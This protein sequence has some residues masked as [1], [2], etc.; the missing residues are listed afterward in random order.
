MLHLHTRLAVVAG[1][2]IACSPPAQCISWG[3][4]PRPR[5][6]CLGDP[7]PPGAVA[8]LGT[9]RFKHNSAAGSVTALHFLADGQTLVSGG[10]DAVS[11]WDLTTAK[12]L[13][14]FAASKGLFGP[15]VSLSGDSKVM[16]ITEQAEHRIQLRD[17][18]TGNV[19]RH[20]STGESDAFPVLAVDGRTVADVRAEGPIRA[21]GSPDGVIRLWDV[22]TGR[23]RRCLKGHDGYIHQVAFSPDG[24]ILAS[25]G[26]DSLVHLWNTTTG[27][28]THRLKG[29]P[30]AVFSVAFA[31]DAQTVA[32]GCDSC[33]RLWDA[34]TGKELWNLSVF[35]VEAL[36]FSPD[37]KTLASGCHTQVCLWDA[38]TGKKL[39]E[40]KGH[41][42]KVTA[43]A[44]SRD[45]KKLASGSLDRTIRLWDLATGKERLPLPGHKTLVTTLAYAP[46]GKVLATGDRVGQVILW[47]AATGKV[48]QQL[49]RDG[50][51]P[52]AALRFSLDGRRL[53][54]GGLNRPLQCW[55]LAA[56]K[57]I[58]REELRPDFYLLTLAFA[59]HGRMLALGTTGAD[60]C[61]TLRDLKTGRKLQSFGQ[62]PWPPAPIAFAPDGRTLAMAP[63]GGRPR[64]WELATGKELCQL[65]GSTEQAR[66]VYAPDGRT[67][68]AVGQEDTMR[69]W[70]V[71][72]GEE[73][74]RWKQPLPSL[75]WLALSPDA[76]LLAG[77]SAD[78]AVCLWE[79]TTGQERCRFPGH[80]G[81]IL[82]LA[83]APDGRTLASGS[84]DTTILIWDV[85]G[86]EPR[87]DPQHHLAAQELRD[88]WADLA[89]ADAPQAHRAIGALARAP[90][91][92][93]PFLQKRLHPVTIDVRQVG[94][95]IRDLD[96]DKFAV[97][98][99]AQERLEEFGELARPALRRTLADRPS[100]EVQ[101]R[102]ERLLEKL[103]QE[104][105]GPSPERLRVLRALEVLERIGSPEAQQVFATLAKGS[106]ESWLTLE[107][108]GAQKRLAGRP[109]RP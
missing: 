74:R 102:V 61:L 38:S 108:Q 25:V 20:I 85:N 79:T 19:I 29:H 47:E 43:V 27:K 109:A 45:S 18:V 15:A 9:N 10:G 81:E 6:D 59:P 106:P 41:D 67:I 72:T 94:S 100:V 57:L 54:A 69:L 11:I 84:V 13:Q 64:L 91:Q 98:E 46:D 39:R 88:L 49:D 101:R 53:A 14:R 71:D 70:D 86:P 97:R 35:R 104:R 96:D 17:A 21:S 63:D 2:A 42:E 30:H 87:G 95:L 1:L 78:G 5:T 76:R 93:V 28:E 89:G 80:R 92:A 23:L 24:K 83:F 12:E 44:F 105:R 58:H 65:A 82:V 34:A 4:E 8:R 32:S 56:G 55:D 48:L 31:P 77:A 3:D 107:A 26:R 40:L 60:H 75:D 73:L 99:R 68:A 62:S 33:I 90:R 103:D 7:L 52:I 66:P 51:D 37:G 22:S 50:T 36:A 16:A